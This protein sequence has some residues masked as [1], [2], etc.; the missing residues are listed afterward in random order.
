MLVNRPAPPEVAGSVRMDDAFGTAQA[1][2]HLLDSGCKVIGLL[3]GPPNS[4]SGKERTRGF[5]AVHSAAS[6]GL[7]PGLVV[8]CIPNSE[9]GYEAA[10]SLLSAHPAIDGLVCYN[11]L[12]AVGA[13]RACAELGLG[14]PDDVALVGCDDIMVAGL[15][16][17]ALTTFRAPRYEIGAHAVRMILDHIVGRREQAEMVLEPE[18]VVR[19]RAPRATCSTDGGEP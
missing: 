5:E 17:A 12:V 16:S 19:D 2:R 9:G 18:L 14:V 3:A 15:V 4:H 1:V 7:E 11:D 10:L 8:P 13:L 6:R